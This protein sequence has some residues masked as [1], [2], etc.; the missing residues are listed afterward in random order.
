MII[1]IW[2]FQ[3]FSW[4][5]IGKW[6]KNQFVWTNLTAIEN[7]S[8]PLHSIVVCNM[9]L[10]LDGFTVVWFS[11]QEIEKETDMWRK[12]WS[13]VDH[14][15]LPSHIKQNY[16]SSVLFLSSTH[17]HSCLTGM[18][19]SNNDTKRQ[20]NMMSGMFSCQSWCTA[21]ASIITVFPPC[22]SSSAFKTSPTFRRSP[23]P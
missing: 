7:T 8:C 2:R 17:T 22:S 15:H 6:R 21:A 23:Y 18:I 10:G 11:L 13:S 9:N 19:R 14:I 3:L 12:S 1:S 16:Y 5:L 20:N 4:A